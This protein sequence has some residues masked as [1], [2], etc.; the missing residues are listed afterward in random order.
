MD[1]KDVKGMYTIKI[2]KRRRIVYEKP[3]GFWHKEDYAR[4]HKEYVTKIIPLLGN[5]KPW[6]L[7]TD[8]RNYKISNIVEDINEHAKWKVKNN[9]A[10]AVMIVNSIVVEMQLKIS[11]GNVANSISFSSKEEA[12]EFLELHGF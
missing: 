5:Q 10:K 8:L 1:I 11:T 4:Y 7:C 2:D 9:L 3:L 12:E 6:A